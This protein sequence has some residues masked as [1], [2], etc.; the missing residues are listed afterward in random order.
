MRTGL[1]DIQGRILA[2]VISMVA[3]TSLGSLWLVY[4]ELREQLDARNL[5]RIHG[6]TALQAQLF[7]TR[8]EEMIRDVELTANSPSMTK[9]LAAEEDNT[10][11]Q[12]ATDELASFGEELLRLRPYDVQIR[13]LN[14]EGRE[15]LRIDRYGEHGSLRRVS[16]TELQ[17]K[18]MRRYVRETLT[19]PPGEYYIS[20][21]NLNREFGEIALPLEPVIRVSLALQNAQGQLAGMLVINQRIDQLFNE[22]A[23]LADPALTVMVIDQEGNYLK[24]I[25]AEKAYAFEFNK[26]ISAFD[27]FPGIERL[28]L[29]DAEESYFS[30]SD[31]PYV[32]GGLIAVRA[33]PYNYRNPAQ[34][35]GIVVLGSRGDIASVAG[36]TLRAA[37][38]IVGL[39]LLLAALAGGWVAQK[40]S[41]PFQQ[42]IKVLDKKGQ[43]TTIPLESPEPQSECERCEHLPVCLRLPVDAPGEAGLLARELR[44]HL[45]EIREKT[46]ALH[47]EVRLREAAQKECQSINRK[48][49]RSN[50]E[51]EQFVYIS[52]HDLR[53][54]LRVIDN[55]ATWLVEDLEDE[56]SG[57][58]LENLH[59]LQQ[60]ARRM[61]RLLDDLLEYSRVGRSFGDKRYQQHISGE[62]ML[63]QLRFLIEDNAQIALKTDGP[64]RDIEVTRMPLQHVL[65]N[66][67]NNAQKHGYAS[68]MEITLTV[69]DAGDFFQFDVED[70]GPGIEA[71]Y[72]EKVFELFQTLRPRDEVEGSGMGLAIV[73]KVLDYYG[74]SIKLT[75]SASG[76]CRFTVMW[77][78]DQHG[79]VEK[80]GGE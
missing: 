52:S 37:A 77:P 51:L 47:G 21:I 53:A 65:A 32:E 58:Q 31:Y 67:I 16:D 39:V 68:G 71:Q 45:C 66:L 8:I 60:R 11:R 13:F 18:S 69:R 1:Q 79:S 72:R 28:F 63:E 14:A 34:K 2:L 24:H 17:D 54:P 59:L 9:L 7:S 22:M 35:I 26:K 27:D 36:D 23:Q 48:L 19:L 15:Q 74:G 61:E 20:G 5:L 4:L 44:A 40:I 10:H 6:E 46:D 75:E 12:S 62:Q 57:E 64:W 42:I 70:N 80:E 33:V 56:L 73:K 38:F 30:Q 50:K 49:M 55:A 25:E 76:G 3:I 78:K 43:I 41:K 29:S